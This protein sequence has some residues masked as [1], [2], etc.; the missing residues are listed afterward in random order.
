MKQLLNVSMGANGHLYR[1]P[2]SEVTDHIL[3]C[4]DAIAVL[5]SSGRTENAFAVVAEDI[6]SGECSLRIIEV[7]PEHS[8]KKLNAKTPVLAIYSTS[9]PVLGDPQAVYRLFD[10]WNKARIKYERDRIA[11]ECCDEPIDPTEFVRLDDYIR[12]PEA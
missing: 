12:Q 5:R 9:M 1:A 3:A 6:S 11:R 2:G 7:G 4:I 10:A 8:L